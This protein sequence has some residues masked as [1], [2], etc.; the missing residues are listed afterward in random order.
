VAK[1]SGKRTE[2]S[3]QAHSTKETGFRVERR[4]PGGEYAVIATL[5]ATSTSYTDDH[6]PARGEYVYRIQASDDA[7]D[8]TYSPSLLVVVEKLP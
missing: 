2:L 6:L 5:P 7:G 4:T 3:W 8:I 1:V